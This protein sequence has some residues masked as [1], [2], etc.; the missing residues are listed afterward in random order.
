LPMRGKIISGVP[1]AKVV[2]CSIVAMARTCRVD[3]DRL[4]APQGVG[5][6]AS[7]CRPMKHESH[8]R[9]EHDAR[10]LMAKV[11]P[12]GVHSSDPLPKAPRRPSDSASWQDNGVNSLNAT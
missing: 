1:L 9:R 8:H 12:Q 5:M 4:N 7:D 2:A 11:V 3:I 6:Y 10:Y